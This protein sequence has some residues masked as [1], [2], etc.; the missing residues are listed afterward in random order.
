MNLNDL[1]SSDADWQY[2][3]QERS[4]RGELVDVHTVEHTQDLLLETFNRYVNWS[5][6]HDAA[7]VTRPHSGSTRPSPGS[8]QSQF[9]P[10]IFMA[11]TELRSITLCNQG[12]FVERAFSAACDQL[13]WYFHELFHGSQVS[14]GAESESIPIDER[15][16]TGPSVRLN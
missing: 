9:W 3:R 12:L 5:R 13:P 16:T 7:H 11:L 14:G 2:A 1:L 10:R 15:L 8:T 6:K 4:N